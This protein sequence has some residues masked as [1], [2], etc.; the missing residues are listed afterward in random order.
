MLILPSK[1]C[2]LAYGSLRGVVPAKIFRSFT[3]LM[4]VLWFCA[5]LLGFDV[6][7]G[8]ASFETETLPS[9]EET[10]VEQCVR[11]SEKKFAHFFPSL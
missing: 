3:S 4:A 2:K 10:A 8:F 11:K 7:F 5:L 6:A 9:V 1:L